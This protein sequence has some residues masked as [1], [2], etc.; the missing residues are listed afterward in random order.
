MLNKWTK[1]SV[2]TTLRHFL[3]TNIMPRPQLGYGAGGWSFIHVINVEFQQAL[4]P[5]KLRKFVLMT[6]LH[7]VKGVLRDILIKM[8]FRI[9]TNSHCKKCKNI[10]LHTLGATRR[11]STMSWV[12]PGKYKA[13]AVRCAW[14][15]IPLKRIM[16]LRGHDGI[17]FRY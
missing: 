14:S 12:K 5:R 16:T 11:G 1:V 15:A 4:I 13:C 9:V 6:S 2:L 3:T 17:I 8:E 10:D 7:G